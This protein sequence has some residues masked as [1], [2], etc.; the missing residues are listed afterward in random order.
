MFE[1]LRPAPEE[2]EE[3]EEVYETPYESH[4]SGND[5]QPAFHTLTAAVWDGSGVGLGVSAGFRAGLAILIPSLP[6]SD[7]APPRSN[8]W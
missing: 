2:S 1:D 8:S 6:L 5:R 7:K 3:V 4:Y